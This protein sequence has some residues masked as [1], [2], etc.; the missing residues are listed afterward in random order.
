MS[1]YAKLIQ[2]DFNLSD[3]SLEIILH[4][5][6]FYPRMN[7]VTLAMFLFVRQIKATYL[8]KVD[9][10]RA[11]THA[12]YRNI[13]SC[14]TSIKHRKKQIKDL[15]YLAQKLSRTYLLFKLLR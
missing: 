7:R 14:V 3:V 11:F 13:T 12:S 9:A 8:S 2:Q 5:K 1:K 10:P 6:V 15:E 4:P